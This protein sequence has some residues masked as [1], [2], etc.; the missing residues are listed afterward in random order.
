MLRSRRIDSSH[1][2]AH[3]A[4]TVRNRLLRD[5]TMRHHERC[6]NTACLS[7]VEQHRQALQIAR[8]FKHHYLA[9]IIYHDDYQM[10]TALV[11]PA[12]RRRPAHEIWVDATGNVSVH[13]QDIRSASQHLS[14]RVLFVLS[15]VLVCLFL[16][17]FI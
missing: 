14:R 11:K 12:D 8:S 13:H 9:Q 15:I 3:T 7:P 2:P 6:L 16:I 1:S 10:T 4:A 5:T 17:I